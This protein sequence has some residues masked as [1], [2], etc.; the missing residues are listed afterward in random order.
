MAALM[1]L[2]D[3]EID[4][5]LAGEPSADPELAP[6]SDLARALR[7][8]AAW[9]PLP[10]LGRPLRDQLA[11]GPGGGAPRRGAQRSL[12]AAAAAVVV[13]GLA[14]V[15]VGAAQNRL[16]ADLQDVVAS[17]AELVGLDVPTSEERSAATPEDERRD[18]AGAVHGQDEEAP[19]DPPTQGGG[20][21]SGDRTTPGGA[22]PADPGVPMDAEPATPAAPPAAATV[23][24]AQGPPEDPASGDGARGD[25]RG[26]PPSPPA[27]SPTA[28][29]GLTTAAR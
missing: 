21:S 14:A 7:T 4:A 28:T 2:E 16:P 29:G 15:T 13:T 24:D 9:E 11:A 12:L 17:T 22:M 10:P 20:D 5:L 18:D 8:R 25:E 27:P 19:G 23:P 3:H 26:T 1:Q 6:I